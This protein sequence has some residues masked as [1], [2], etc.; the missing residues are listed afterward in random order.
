MPIMSVRKSAAYAKTRKMIFP[1]VIGIS[2]AVCKEFWEAVV[3]FTQA[4]S[5]DK[6][7]SE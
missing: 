1:V 3:L 4:F 7:L 6:S 5:H 2:A